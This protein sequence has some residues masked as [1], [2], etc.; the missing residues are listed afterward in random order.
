LVVLVA[1]IGVFVTVAAVRGV[2]V[3]ARCESL[4]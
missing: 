3:E 2:I 4:G 1:L